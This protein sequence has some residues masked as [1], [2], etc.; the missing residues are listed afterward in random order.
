MASLTPL[1]TPALFSVDKKV[2]FV[3]GGGSGLGRAI[4]QGASPLPS[5]PS[6]CLARRP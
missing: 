4:A 2:V 3:T 5:L 1:L 6:S